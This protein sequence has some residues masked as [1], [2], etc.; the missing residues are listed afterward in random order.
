V[1]DR[2]CSLGKVK[3]EGTVLSATGQIVEE[4]WYWLGEHFENVELDDFV[5]MPNH[6]HGIVII[7]DPRRGGSRT[8]PTQEPTKPLGRLIGAFKTVSTKRINELN[9]TPGMVFWQRNF[10]DHIIRNEKDL[11]RIRTYIANNPLR[12]ALDE[13]N[14]DEFRIPY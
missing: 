9:E 10:Y 3:G 14:P 5:I 6:I 1:Q 13:E 2:V 12:W 4:V 7:N 8:A 11:H